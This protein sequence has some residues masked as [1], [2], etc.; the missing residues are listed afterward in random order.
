MFIHRSY[1]WRSTKKMRHF[2]GC[3]N[4]HLASPTTLDPGR[5][6][7]PAAMTVDTRPGKHTN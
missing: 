4:H 1:K 5:S 7:V 6:P 2:C 3:S